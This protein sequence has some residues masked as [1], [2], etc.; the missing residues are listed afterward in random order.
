MLTETVPQLLLSQKN[1]TALLPVYKAASEQTARI[2]E[3]CSLDGRDQS[4][5]VW[6]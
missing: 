4:V 2:L 1:M 3:Q 6:P 5:D